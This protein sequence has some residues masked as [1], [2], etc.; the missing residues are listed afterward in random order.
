MG[1]RTTAVIGGGASGALAVL[2]LLR[3]SDDDVVL[4]EPGTPG[5]GVA[6]GAARPWHL[7]NSRAC[8]MS[9]DPDDPGHFVTWLRGRGIDAGP[10]SFLPRRHFG[11]YLYACLDAEACADPGR[12]RLFGAR[13]AR[14]GVDG[15]GCS[16][17]L[18]DGR[19]LRV[20]RAVL[21]VGAAGPAH[22]T[23]ATDAVRSHAAYV[24]DPWAPGALDAVPA[25]GPV[26][27]LGTALTAVDV[28]ATLA[29][30][31]SDA[32]VTAVSRHGLLPQPHA[33]TH[34]PLG[35]VRT[36]AGAMLAGR[37]L[38]AVIRQLREAAGGADW[39]T[40]VDG[41]RPHVDGIW[42]GLD[43]AEQDRFL[44]HLSRHW[45]THRHRMA[46]EVAAHVD[47]L[48]T[49][50]QLLVRA[51]RVT[52]VVPDGAGLDVSFGDGTRQ[53]YAAVVNCTGPGRLPVAANPLVATLL[54]D[55]LVRT[56][57]H[58]LGL[59]VDAA[60]RFRDAR[61]AAQPLLWSLGPARRGALWETTA[62][63]EIRA[64]A[65]ALAEAMAAERA[66][67]AY[68]RAAA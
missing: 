54:A 11:R 59:D 19:L 56:G 37:G 16:L 26:L 31:P 55:R 30:T 65:R 33:A 12:L 50:G 47:A 57:P 17:R 14:L 1:R 2:Q 60:G 43:A 4:V 45:E 46:P 36:L 27:L 13:V 49:G 6:Y 8:A 40:V 35:G 9:A 64:Q 39:R 53:R 44:R 21:A 52:R 29:R 67:D 22:P 7:L 68:D 25:R 42:A 41:V 61:G 23:A 18:D 48:R 51:A 62:V 10:D 34:A 66:W 38:R 28:V 32:P 24:A 5:A 3:C 20:D 63:P 15:D 58:G